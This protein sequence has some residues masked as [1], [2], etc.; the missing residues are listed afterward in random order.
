[1][2]QYVHF[3]I[4]NSS[5]FKQKTKD[6]SRWYSIAIYYVAFCS[7]FW[8]CCGNGDESKPFKTYELTTGRIAIH[9]PA[10]IQAFD[11]GCGAWKTVAQSGPMVN[12]RHYHGWSWMKPSP[13]GRFM[14]GSRRR[15]LLVGPS[16]S[17]MDPM[18]P[19]SPASS[20]HSTCFKISTI[21]SNRY[22]PVMKHVY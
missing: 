3:P 11:S 17:H 13:N 5:I 22:P 9:P 12:S 21:I 4:Q 7:S 1:M 18:G 10:T 2:V 19:R 14:V 20:I 6:S 15:G 8:S 16:S